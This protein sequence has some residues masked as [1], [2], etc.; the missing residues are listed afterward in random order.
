MR[1]R[2]RRIEPSIA[3]LNMKTRAQK[4]RTVWTIIMRPS[5]RKKGNIMSNAEAPATMDRSRVP[6]FR[7]VRTA[8]EDVAQGMKYVNLQIKSRIRKI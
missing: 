4:E 6:S 7:S 3:Q 2:K 5:V 1:P 8:K